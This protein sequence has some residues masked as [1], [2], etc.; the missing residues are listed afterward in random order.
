MQ[1]AH[2]QSLVNHWMPQVR[3]W[4]IL[5]GFWGLHL[6]AF[7]WFLDSPQ[8]LA[9][10]WVDMDVASLFLL[11]MLA[12]IPL[13]LATILAFSTADWWRRPAL[14]V[15][16]LVLLDVMTW[17]LNGGWKNPRVYDDVV[18]H[19]LPFFTA[20]GVTTL[21]ASIGRWK[22]WHVDP[23]L[24]ERISSA[25]VSLRDLFVGITIVAACIPGLDGLIYTCQHQMGHPNEFQIVAS[26][27]LGFITPPATL[28][29]V[30]TVR[31]I[32]APLAKRRWALFLCSIGWL[33]FVVYT[34]ILSFQGLGWHS[35]PRF[36]AFPAGVMADAALGGFLL[37]GLGYRVGPGSWQRQN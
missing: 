15:V 5:S 37:R 27:V 9:F 36:L 19:W 4:A 32:V 22:T 11:G 16:P 18:W 6:L 10:G 1:Q 34:V 31:L 12:T 20:A 24:T 14:A 29:L 35:A 28:I 23:L 2:E 17:H 25:Q 8:A 7:K 21:V 13:W 33:A 30:S 3:R 26:F